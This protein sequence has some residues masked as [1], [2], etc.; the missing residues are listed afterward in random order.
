M[1]LLDGIATLAGADQPITCPLSKRE[2]GRD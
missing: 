2:T 1:R